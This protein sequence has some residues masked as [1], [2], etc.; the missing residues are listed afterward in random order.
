M[1]PDTHRNPSVSHHLSHFSLLNSQFGRAGCRIIVLI[2]TTL[3]AAT[4]LQAADPPARP[5]VVV[6][7]ADDMGFSDIGCYGSEI[8]TPN[9][10]RLAAGGLRF[11]QFYN[12]ARCCPTRA[13]LLTG[14]YQHQAGIG[15]MVGDDGL[16]AY[17]GFLNDRCVTIAEALGRGGYRTYMAGK[18]HVG[19][20]PPH[21]P[22]Q[23]GFERFFGLV[24]GASNFWRLDKGRQMAIDDEPY[25][26][27]G[28]DFYMT[29]AFTDHAVKF[30]EEHGKS[31]KP[32][33]LYLPYTAPHWP[34]HAWPEDI[35]KYRG[36]YLEGWDALRRARH[37][38]MIDMGI[39]KSDWPLTPR[40]PDAP[41]W[42]NVKNKR[43]RDLKMAV[44]AAQIDRMDQ[45]IGRV[46]QAVRTIG[47]EANTLVLFLADNGGCAE[48]VNRGTKGVPPG[49]A[50]SFLS[51][52]LPWA[53]ASNTPFRLYKHWVHEGGISTPL[54]AYWPAVIKQG[55]KITPQ[56]GHLIDIM[57]TCLDV[58]GTDYPETHK[59]K[60]ITPL[61][62]KSLLPILKGKQR[63]GHDVIY[64]EHEGNRAV[65]QGKWKIVSRH[66]GD[67]ELYD[68]EADRTELNDLAPDHPDKVKQLARLYQAWAHRV[69]AMPGDELQRHRKARR[70]ARKRAKKKAAADLTAR[71]TARLAAHPA[72]PPAAS[73][74][75]ANGKP[76]RT[77]PL[78]VAHRGFSHKAPENTLAAYR[79]AIETG[80]EMAECDVRLSADGVPVVIHDEKL[81]R[82]AQAP[83]KVGDYPLAELKKLDV[84]RWKSDKYRGERIPTL[85]EALQLVKGKLRFVIEIKGTDM[86]RQVVDA[87]GAADVA[88]EDVMIFSFQYDAVRR[89]AEIEPLLPTTWLIGE[90]PEDPA[91]Y[92]PLIRQSLQARVSAVGLSQKYARSDFLFLAHQ[93]GLQVFF[94]TVNKAPDMRR[95]VRLGA[96]GIIS[97]RPDLLLEVLRET[98][99]DHDGD[100]HE[101]GT[102]DPRR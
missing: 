46:M 77:H 18:W 37:Q 84:G 32:F 92:R 23:R 48:E 19:E 29:D 39:V 22:R 6:V 21:W 99:D 12:T 88:P 71:P 75:S 94:W 11:T 9:L 25:V 35:A 86:E 47:A 17:R 31:D 55:G 64:W 50:D 43:M 28:E 26:P 61:E 98:A 38:R 90:L 63:K 65:R 10:D 62:G 53:N 66:P 52:G 34:L 45:N 81:E 96:D 85:V 95:L 41:V 56:T 87:I 57:A 44:Y 13:A 20:R 83:G 102:A 42:E 82:T 3:P 59:G 54:I 33:F 79:L 70:E 2:V 14:L 76:V 72:T 49:P 73:R 67:W 15:H 40:D 97:D 80:V 89:I 93:C 74:K 91:A 68:L 69:G 7:M 1:K 30:I 101:E 78:A 16:P 5:N 36:K 27:V 51:Y 100:E 4:P 8:A 58:S 60:P 24:S